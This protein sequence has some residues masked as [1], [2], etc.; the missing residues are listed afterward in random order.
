MSAISGARSNSLPF[1]LLH[2]QALSC[3]ARRHCSQRGGRR[4]DPGLV[5]QIL[6]KLMFLEIQAL[7]REGR[8]G[9]GLDREG[10]FGCPAP[11]EIHLSDL[12]C[13]LRW[14]TQHFLGVLV[15]LDNQMQ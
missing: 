7:A 10:G 2:V 1:Y 5:H 12:R 13:R 9:F 3:S 8:F 14:S 6:G 15:P 11:G 4:F